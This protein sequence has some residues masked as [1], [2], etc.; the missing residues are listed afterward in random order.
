MK[1][2]MHTAFWIT[3]PR[4]RDAEI[5]WDRRN[6]EAESYEERV[7]EK[8][9][10]LIKSGDEGLFREAIREGAEEESNLIIPAMKSMEEGEALLFGI[11]MMEIVRRHYRWAAEESIND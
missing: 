7:E 1:S 8:M 2:F 9:Q 10:E 5:E 6:E 3:D 4:I 11:R